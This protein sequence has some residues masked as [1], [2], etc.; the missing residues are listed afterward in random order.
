M[1]NVPLGTI[2]TYALTFIA[3]LLSGLFSKVWAD[4]WTDAR[5]RR[6]EAASVRKTFETIRTAMPA[7]LEEMR[8]DFAAPGGSMVREFVSLPTS[9]VIFN[10]GGVKRFVYYET[11]HPDLPGKI[12]MLE[13]LGYIRDVRVSNW[14]IYRMSPEFIDLLLPKD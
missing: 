5:R 10:H 1:G 14:P 6:A 13:D 8:A 9:G 4:S 7:L 12:A 2:G 3:G 11:E